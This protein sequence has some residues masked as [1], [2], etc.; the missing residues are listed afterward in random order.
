MPRKRT[1]ERQLDIVTEATKMLAANGYHSVTTKALSKNLGVKEMI[2]YRCFKNKDAIVLACIIET[3]KI[4]LTN[5]Q[6]VVEVEKDPMEALLKIAA[7]FSYNPSIKS[8]GFQLLQRL[9][10]E[11]LESELN[12]AIAAIYEQFCNFLEKHLNR[13]IDYYQLGEH[14]PEK[15]RHLAWVLVQWGSGLGQLQLLP[16]EESHDTNFKTQQVDLAMNFI[17]GHLWC[18]QI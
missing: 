9:C 10:A 7:D 2:L 17:K 4:Q 15:I 5:W 1:S 11:Q 14:N 16:I 12:A 3:G 8:T 6:K 18:T 13:I